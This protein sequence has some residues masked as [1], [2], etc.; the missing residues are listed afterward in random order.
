VLREHIA[1]QGTHEEKRGRWRIGRSKNAGSG[2]AFKVVDDDAQS[3]SRRTVFC[4]SV[5]WQE[6]RCAACVLVHGQHEARGNHAL[7]EGNESFGK[8]AKNNARIAVRG[9]DRDQIEH[10]LRRLDVV[11]PLHRGAKQSFLRVGVTKKGRRRDAQLL[12][13]LG[14]RRG[15][16]SLGRKDAPGA[17]QK[18]IAAD[19][20]WPAHL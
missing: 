19:G 15:G 14:E 6:N 7:H 4:G 18:L 20:R 13:D 8:I 5:E 9:V 16:E 12:C 17:V 1:L 10:A 3:A 2:C 11:R